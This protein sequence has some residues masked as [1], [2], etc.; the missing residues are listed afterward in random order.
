MVLPGSAFQEAT[1]STRPSAVCTSIVYVD[2]L[3][4]E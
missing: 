4:S 1:C 2:Q 3:G